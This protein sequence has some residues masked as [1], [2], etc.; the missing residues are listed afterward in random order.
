MFLL[1][2]PAKQIVREHVL[3]VPL[4]E[5]FSNL[6]SIFHSAGAGTVSVSMGPNGQDPASRVVTLSGPMDSAHATLSPNGLMHKEFVDDLRQTLKAAH[7]K[8]VTMT[9][10][11]SPVE[12]TIECKF[13]VKVPM[14]L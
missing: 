8:L 12:G 11:E 9:Y 14:N 13:Y 3:G 10:H 4:Q 5:D 2:T 7:Y 6:E 1:S